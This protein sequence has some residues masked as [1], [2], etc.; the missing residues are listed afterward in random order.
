MTR[1]LLAMPR[2]RVSLKQ[3]GLLGWK[4]LRLWVYMAIVASQ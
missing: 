1:V 3:D 4:L 2:Q